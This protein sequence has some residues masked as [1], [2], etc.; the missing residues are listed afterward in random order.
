MIYAYLKRLKGQISPRPNEEWLRL[1]HVIEEGG[2][3]ALESWLRDVASLASDLESN[4]EVAARGG[5]TRYCLEKVRSLEDLYRRRAFAYK[6]AIDVGL[7]HDNKLPR[8]YSSNI[9]LLI[10]RYAR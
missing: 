2:Q 5:K 8:L 10:N 4:F 3:P 1:K 7:I 9:T 6:K